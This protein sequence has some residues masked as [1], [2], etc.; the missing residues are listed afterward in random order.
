MAV[1]HTDAVVS[2]HL[3]FARQVH[4][5][6]QDNVGGAGARV[7]QLVAELGLEPAWELVAPLVELQRNLHSM[8]MMLI[9]HKA[10][11]LLLSCSK[12]VTTCS[13]QTI[14]LHMDLFNVIGELSS[15]SGL[16]EESLEHIYGHATGRALA[17]MPMPR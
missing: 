11:V 7:D 2:A 15:R 6:G 3:H 4:A 16:A 8:I 10:A 17:S 5:R 13:K 9:L 1:V 12:F 14:N